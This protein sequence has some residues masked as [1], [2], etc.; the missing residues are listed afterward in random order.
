LRK[1]AY[2]NEWNEW[3]IINWAIG[4]ANEKFPTTSRGWPR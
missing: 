2:V 3:W 1:H 4:C